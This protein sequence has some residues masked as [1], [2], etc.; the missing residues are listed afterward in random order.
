MKNENIKTASSMQNAIS[1]TSIVAKHRRVL[2][3]NFYENIQVL[4]K[5]CMQL[6]ESNNKIK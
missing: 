2:W 1:D 5:I 3:P 4:N 6:Y